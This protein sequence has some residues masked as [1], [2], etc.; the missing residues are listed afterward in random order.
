LGS[1]TLRNRDLLI[2]GGWLM[3]RDPADHGF[4]EAEGP[5]SFLMHLLLYARRRRRRLSPPLQLLFLLL[6]LILLQ[7]LDQVTQD[8]DADDD[9]DADKAHRTVV[10]VTGKE[11]LW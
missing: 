5:A 7:P 9:E 3:G 8:E 4:G 6:L 1:L 10:V 11:D 2:A